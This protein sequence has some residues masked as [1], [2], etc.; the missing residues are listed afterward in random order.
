MNSNTP[1][2]NKQRRRSGA[3][4]R[5]DKTAEKIRRIQDYCREN[6]VSVRRACKHF[7]M[8]YSYVIACVRRLLAAKTPGVV[9]TSQLPKPAP[10]ARRPP[11]AKN[12]R[13][14]RGVEQMAITVRGIQDLCREHKIA[15]TE[16]CRRTGHNYQTVTFWT[17]RLV[18]L[19]IPGIE[20][21][22]DLAK[23]ARP[24]FVR[25]PLPSLPPRDNPARQYADEIPR[26]RAMCLERNITMKA[27]CRQLN[28]DYEKIIG[29][30]DE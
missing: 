30:I 17:N 19:K 21:N 1:Q 6:S 2:N 14:N 8:N 16:A 15:V 27:A 12:P 23:S 22:S 3:G 9:P 26:L 24:D 20:R 18:D 7:G 28:I 4:A 29:L 25:R 11:A 5:T 10:S 13:K